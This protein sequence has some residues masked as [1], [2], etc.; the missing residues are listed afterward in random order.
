MAKL[1]PLD[2]WRLAETLSVIDAAILIA[3][4]NP[5]DHYW[6]ENEER[7]K[8]TWQHDGFDAAF[9]ALKGA[10]L[11]N[12]LAANIRHAMRKGR[13]EY[14]PD[15]TPFTPSAGHDEDQFS[16]DMLVARHSGRE[17]PAIVSGKTRLNFAVDDLRSTRFL[18]IWKD[19]NWMETT[20][21]VDE[22]KRWLER[23]GVFPAFFFPTG[24]KDSFRN[25]ENPRYSPKL[26]CAIAAWEAISR[27]APNKSVKQTI[28]DWVQSN[29]VRFGLGENMV[30]SPTAAEEVAKIVNWNPKGGANP[31]SSGVSEEA[32]DLNKHI[33][34]YGFG[35]PTDG[36]FGTIS[37]D[38]MDSEI[39]F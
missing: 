23:R 2:L 35:Y 25:A 7:H 1:A 9:S 31:T 18:Y 27:A 39:P 26:A 10:I 30:V 13:T 8:L 11:S 20:I 4:G 21:D 14:T 16:Y 22:L 17:A 28:Q 29:G 6:D 34:N 32:Q 24:N 38:D 33:E 15:G 5:N 19:P 36:G 3:G 37:D 12:R